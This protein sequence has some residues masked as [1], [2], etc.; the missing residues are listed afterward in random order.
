[1]NRRLNHRIE[2]KEHWQWTQFEII[3]LTLIKLRTRGMEAE[4]KLPETLEGR[5][6]KSPRRK[7]KKK[8]RVRCVGETLRKEDRNDSEETSV[9]MAF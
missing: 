4:E 6:G 7:Q 1:M 2:K 9:L 5:E 3:I 8:M